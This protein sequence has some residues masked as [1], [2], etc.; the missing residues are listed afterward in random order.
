MI[1]I[2][3]D[4]VDGTEVSYIEGVELKDNFNTCCLDFF[5]FDCEAED[6]T[7]HKSN[8]DYIRRNELLDD[9]H[10]YTVKHIRKEHNLVKLL[11][12][13]TFFWK[14]DYLIND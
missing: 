3:Y 11:K 1:H 14:N 7:V 5:C 4:F 6:V 10:E 9:L 12:A 2:H 8:G 13:N